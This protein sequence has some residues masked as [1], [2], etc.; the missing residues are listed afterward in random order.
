MDAVSHVAALRHNA[1]RLSHAS[2]VGAGCTCAARAASR[3]RMI[4]SSAAA[5]S[6]V[7]LRKAAAATETADLGMRASE[8]TAAK[9]GR[10]TLGYDSGAGVRLRKGHTA[11]CPGRA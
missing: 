4:R 11:A 1:A 7:G 6:R 5:C 8:A 9:R 10:T 2:L 3:A